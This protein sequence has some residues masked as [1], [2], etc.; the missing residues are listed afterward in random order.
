MIPFPIATN[1]RILNMYESLKDRFNYK[2][3]ILRFGYPSHLLVYTN[4]F[5]MKRGKDY[6][7]DLEKEISQNDFT[8]RL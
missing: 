7:G 6:K 5:G 4:N 3:L 2:Y 1:P 8:Q